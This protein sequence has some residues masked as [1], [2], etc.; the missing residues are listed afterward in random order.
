VP[1][2]L[3]DEDRG[4]LE[5]ARSSGILTVE[6]RYGRVTY[7][8]LAEIDRVLARDD[9]ARATAAGTPANRSVIRFRSAFNRDRW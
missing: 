5:K 3:T 2:V 6:T 1:A 9:A 7:R 8:S 4:T